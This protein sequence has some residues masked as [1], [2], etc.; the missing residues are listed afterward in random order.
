M[1]KLTTQFT[2]TPCALVAG[3]MR[4]NKVVTFNAAVNASSSAFPSAVA[5]E[6]DE[7]PYV[8]G[9]ESDAEPSGAESVA[10]DSVVESVTSSGAE[11]DA[12]TRRLQ[13]ADVRSTQLDFPQ[14]KKNADGN[15]FP[16]FPSQRNYTPGFPTA[17][18]DKKKV[19]MRDTTPRGN[20]PPPEEVGQPRVHAEKN[21]HWEVGNTGIFYGNW[22][23][24]QTVAMGRKR[25]LHDNIDLQ[26]N[27]NPAMIITLSEA[28]AE[29][30]ESLQATAVAGD[31]D[32]TGLEK[33]PV[34]QHFCLRGTE[35]CS[36]LIAVRRNN[37]SS[38]ELLYWHRNDDRTYIEKGRKKIARSRTMVCRATM[39]QNV[40]HIGTE[41]NICTTHLNNR[42]A[43]KEWAAVAEAYWDNL[44]ARIEEFNV[45]FLTGDFNMSLTIVC[46]E[47]RS[48]GISCDL[49]AWY[50]WVWTDPA[51]GDLG[52]PE[53]LGFDSCGIFYIGG[54]VQVKM[55]W[56]FSQ[57]NAL[58]AYEVEGEVGQQELDVYDGHCC[59]G[60]HWM[61]YQPKKQKSLLEKL[62]PMLEPT[63]SPEELADI[64]RVDYCP[65]L[66]LNQKK[67]DKELW[68]VEGQ[69]HN[70]AHFPLCVFTNNAGHRSAEAEAR[71]TEK[72]KGKGRGRR[73]SAVAEKSRKGG[74][75]Q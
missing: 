32:G 38:L 74:R 62:R 19:K 60:Q 53:P 36:T 11:D 3:G 1:L 20:A 45:H 39:K 50:P 57:L 48:R 18:A 73:P 64:P 22:G 52:N 37:A 43:K 8:Y 34:F 5:D 44:V 68:L 51:L 56:G 21:R 30:Q 55:Q 75:Y 63:C 72:M 33:R 29:V 67:L 14:P 71:R 7:Y 46:A 61:A 35:L 59:P 23:Q 31:P 15:T 70:G 2:L 13:E 54:N 47:L 24:R 12:T 69:R 17:V 4:K 40:G 25:M 9:P 65:H 49:A 28:T 41:V 10:G 58:A 26:V 6:Y 42:T 27:R 66:C 16:G